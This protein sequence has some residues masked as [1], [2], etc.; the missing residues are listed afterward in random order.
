MIPF[1]LGTK[2]LPNFHPTNLELISTFLTAIG[3]KK[4]RTTIVFKD[5]F[6]LFAV[7]LNWT[8]I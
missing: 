2:N 4:K 3:L 7:F 8:N 5:F 6:V 1:E